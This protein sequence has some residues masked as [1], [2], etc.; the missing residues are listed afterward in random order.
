[1]GIGLFRELANDMVLQT[2]RET[3]RSAFDDAETA[4]GFGVNVAIATLVALSSALFVIQTYT[5]APQ[6]QAILSVIDD[7]ILIVFAIEYL[8]RLWSAENRL[9]HL[10]SLESLIDLIAVLPL[11]AGIF[12]I[13]YL[14]LLRWLRWLRILRLARL[15]RIKSQVNVAS[16]IA[17]RIVFTLFAI[18]FIYAGTIY[19]VEHPVNPTIFRT[20]LDAFYFS[21]VTMTTVGFGDVT[22]VS[23]AGRILTVMMILTGIAL[24]PTQVNS[25][26]QTIN[27]ANALDNQ[28]PDPL[29]PTHPKVTCG[30]CGLDNHTSD[31]LFC[32]QCGTSLPEAQKNA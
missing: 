23:E 19:Q 29:A 18:I 24:I 3:V 12:D 27:R 15:L 10:L 22:P 2:W 13:R 7:G 21:V 20:F 4:W 31:A 17:G 14:R 5:L 8:L 28:P 1:V 25:L 16:L 6:I 11:L 32:R 9:T 30:Q 26:I